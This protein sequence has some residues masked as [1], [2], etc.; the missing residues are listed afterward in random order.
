[1]PLDEPFPLNAVPSRMAYM[2]V[3]EFNGR[4]PS[5]REVDQIPDKQ[6]LATPGIGPA[7]LQA[8]RSI[9]DAA[10]QQEISHATSH[11][12]SDSELLRRLEGLQKDLRW[13]AVHLKARLSKG[14]RR[15]PQHQG[16]NG[17]TRQGTDFPGH[18]AREA[19]PS[20]HR[21]D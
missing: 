10:R 9:T 12:L 3:R 21:S 6:W 5:I 18:E 11:R 8:I 1:M 19:E 4:C 14:P 15:R 13:L 16:H 7:F 17:A 2:L 20:E